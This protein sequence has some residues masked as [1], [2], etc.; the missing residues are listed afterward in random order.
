LVSFVWMYLIADEADQI[1]VLPLG[2]TP[3]SSSW[4]GSQ[5]RR[6]FQSLCHKQG[7]V[8]TGGLC[9]HVPDLGMVRALA[10]AE[11]QIDAFRSALP[12]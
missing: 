8:T 3:L 10:P 4:F 5:W 7:R 1:K 6:D 11:C 2:F 9:I 12:H